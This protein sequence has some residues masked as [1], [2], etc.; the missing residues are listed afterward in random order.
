MG[1]RKKDGGGLAVAGL[2]LFASPWLVAR[3][4]AGTGWGLVGLAAVVLVTCAIVAVRRAQAQL[5]QARASLW[6]AGIALW[7]GPLA[8]CGAVSGT[9]SRLA[10]EQERAAAAVEQRAEQERLARQAAVAAA[11]RERVA[12]EAAWFMHEQL[13]LPAE[14]QAATVLARLNALEPEDDPQPALCYARWVLGRFTRADDAQQS[15]RAARKRVAAAERTLLRQL[16]REAEQGRGILCRDGESSPSCMCHGSWQG[17]CS[18]H[19]GIAGC[20]PID[21]PTIDCPERSDE[22]QVMANREANLAAERRVGIAS[23]AMGRSL[24]P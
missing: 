5:P 11:A 10:E 15:V 9:E 17:C 12:E 22:E 7:L 13:A 19:G 3:Y 2:G 14:S 4:D 20:E 21:P 16:T 24:E 8:Y 1:K 18:H 23:G 6:G